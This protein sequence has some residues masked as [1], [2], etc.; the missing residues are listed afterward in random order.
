MTTAYSPSKKMKVGGIKVHESSFIDDGVAIGADTCIWHF[1]HVLEGSEIG[2]RCRI[3]QNV[4][5]GPRVKVGDNV[6]IQ[7]NVSVY[8]GVTLEDDVFCG[9]SVVFTNVHTPRS[10]FSRNQIEDFR[11]TFVCRGAS[12][13]ANATVVCGCRIGEH[14]LVGAGAVVTR[15][16]PPHAV[17]YGNP[18]RQHGWACECGS[19]LVVE[20]T[21]GKCNECDRKYCI[22]DSRVSRRAEGATSISV[23]AK[24][25]DNEPIPV[26]DVRWQYLELQQEIDEALKAVAANGN[27]ILGPNVKAFEK[28]VAT[29]F[30]SEFAVGVGSGTDALHLA[31]R[32]LNIGPGDEVITSP[33]TFVATTEAIGLTGATP[34]FVDIDPETFNIDERLIESKITSRT[35]AIMPV[36]LYGRPCEM[37]AIMRLA[38]KYD[39]YVVEDCAQSFG[40]TFNG[41]P[42]GTFGD[43]GCFSFFPTKNIGC[44]GD[45]GLVIT[46]NQDVFSRVEMLRRHG[47]RKKYYHEELGL[48]SRLDEIQAAILRLKLP[49]IKR[50]NRLRQNAAKR[51]SRF[52]KNIQTKR[53]VDIPSLVDRSSEMESYQYNFEHVF[54]Q[55][56]IRC[57][58]RESLAAYLKSVGIS[59]AVY[60]PTPLHLQPVHSK[61]AVS[62]ED[63]INSE[64]AAKEVISLPMFPGLSN[65]Q[66]DRVCCEIHNWC[67]NSFKEVDKTC[68]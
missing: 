66:I 35:R 13:G 28:E 60:Y 30:G 65:E 63:L 3:G 68:I 33:F 53:N 31:L 17:V 4:V 23:K 41:K 64:V 38:K 52:F 34:V 56:T 26:C 54:H 40:A 22:K 5:I 44:M 19:V 15:D 8:E 51:Y 55:Y 7:N 12:I 59:T 62:T 21:S 45:G 50:W 58:G 57:S 48:N 10:A 20:E 25:K 29:F 11:G 2:E 6:K 32:A 24:C 36:H 49:H 67:S 14:A 47:G 1:S 18:A 16:V 37:N 61:D 27:Y 39:L 9:P 42:V 43:I 46:K